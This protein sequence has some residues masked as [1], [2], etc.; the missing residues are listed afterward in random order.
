MNISVILYSCIYNMK[1]MKFRNLYFF[2]SLIFLIPGLISLALF[3][4]RPSVD[5]SGGTLLEVQ[6]SND[7][8]QILD[9]ELTSQ[10]E[11]KFQIDSVQSSGECQFILRGKEISNEQKDLVLNALQMQFGEVQELRFE[12]VGPTLGRELLLKTL[13]AVAVVASIITLY[14]WRQFD[15]L[16]YGVCAILAMFHDSLILLGSF[17]LLGHFFGV[18]VDV[19]FVTALLTTLS[20]SVHDTIVVYDRIRELKRLHPKLQFVQIVNAAVIQTLARSINNSLTII[21]M[22]LSLV[23]LG[24]VTIRWFAVALLIGSIT[25]TYSS[26][27][28]AAPLLL[29]WEQVKQKRNLS[30]RNL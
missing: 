13:I 28:T 3:G 10:L 11:G 6:M 16:K 30:P 15:E 4:L 8:C 19:L 23:L 25:G 14:V 26:T 22:L 24:G 7:K 5:F 12:T 21:L 2:I 9:S 1:L 27:F 29:L 20:F 17:S 18:E